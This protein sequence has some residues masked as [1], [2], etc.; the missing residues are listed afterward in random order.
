VI[1]IGAAMLT[2]PEM[3]AAFSG[4]SL[5]Q[6]MLDFEAGLAR[7]EAAAGLIPQAAAEAIASRCRVALFDVAALYRESAAAGTPA[8]PLVRM[9][10]HLVEGDAQGVV[11]WGAT[12]QDA[13][14]TAM[15]LQMREGLDLLLRRLLALARICAGLAERHRRTP[16]A[17]RTLLQHAVPITFGLKSARWLGVVTRLHQRLH[18][19]QARALVVQ[20]GGAAGTLASLG[21]QGVRVME[22]LARELNLA[23][24]E[25]P[26]HAE[27]D[28]VGE[29]A[30]TL[31]V[32][33]SAMAKM[34]NDIALLGQTEVG[35]VSTGAQAAT[36]RSSTM[37]Q[38]RNPVEAMAAS[39]CA[40]LAVGLVPVLLSAGAHE[41]ERAV[42][43][44]QAEW[45]AVPELFQR[46]AG[47]VEWVHRAMADL[48]V[49]ADRMRAN[50]EVTDGLIMAE[51][52]STAL[53]QHI[54]RGR[55]YETVQRICDLA[56]RQGM[57]LRAIAASDEHIR[58]VLSPDQIERA[59]DVS[60]YLGSSDAFIDRAL[61]GFR[62]ACS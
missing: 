43:G 7:A 38:K 46:T 9:L 18:E 50:L 62:R 6:R 10:T 16:M 37:P 34:A 42:G 31:G 2:T 49:D 40:R 57:H 52:L 21:D 24:P 53:A 22:L 32:T 54:G 60:A 28:R 39:A 44:W 36:G 20:F 61:D 55:A 35:E 1:D 17:G 30:A 41:H 48:E 5:I 14:D 51:S 4:T 27:R 58:A 12:S 3:S 25:I 11:H 59:F 33:A 23:V 56:V 13:I 8:V 45:E 29:V 47:A 19:A 15:I 26:W